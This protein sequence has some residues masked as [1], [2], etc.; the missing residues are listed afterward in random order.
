MF[1]LEGGTG[2]AEIWGTAFQERKQSLQDLEARDGACFAQKA[3]SP[4][5]LNRREVRAGR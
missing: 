3:G 1:G 5:G 4:K 2:C